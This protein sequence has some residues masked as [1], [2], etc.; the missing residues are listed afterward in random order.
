LT[1]KPT[2]YAANVDEETLAN[3]DSNP[4]VQDVKEHAARETPKSSS[5]AP[6]SKPNLSRSRPK[7][8]RIS[9]RSGLGI[10][11]RGNLIKAAYKMLGLMSFLTAGE[12]KSAPGRFPSIPKR[13]KRRAKS[14]PTLNAALSAPKCSYDDLIGA[15]S[16]AAA[17][18]KV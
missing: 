1:T 13:R 7:T 8:P 17:R 18:K 2:I 10:E 5:S 12:K 6:S 9:E 15:G 14:I 3:P 16:Y 11:R 4:H